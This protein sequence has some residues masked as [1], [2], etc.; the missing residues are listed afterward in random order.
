MS[1]ARR[2]PSTRRTDSSRTATP[3]RVDPEGLLC[4][5]VL[6]P[7]TFSRNRF[8]V[9]HQTPLVRRVRRRA[10]RV[11]GLVRQL[12]GEGRLRAELIGEQVLEDDQVLLHLRVADLAF[13][14]TTALTPLEASVMRYALHRA[15][16]GELE[17]Q[18]K[19]RVEAALGRLGPNLKGPEAPEK[20]SA[21]ARRG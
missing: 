20:P 14:R 2:R 12:L 17:T 16:T 18:D 19:E 10:A 7:H 11:R 6:A 8:F 21:A 1:R 5:L 13:E 4:A 15:G 9:L 3:A